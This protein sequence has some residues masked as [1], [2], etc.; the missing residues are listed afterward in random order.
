MRKLE[1]GSKAFLLFFLILLL[2]FAAKHYERADKLQIDNWLMMRD[3]MVYS[4]IDK[5]KSAQINDL[6]KRVIH[7]DPEKV[8]RV[9]KMQ[10]E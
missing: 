3:T 9:R 6:S 2:W 7:A 5:F 10:P 4:R 8:K 1:Q